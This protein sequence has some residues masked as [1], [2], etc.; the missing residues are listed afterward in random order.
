VDRPPAD[1]LHDPMAAPPRLITRP[2]AS[3]PTLQDAQQVAP[4]TGA[5]ATMVP[6]QA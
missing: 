4:A 1:D 2:P 6:R 3:L 5:S